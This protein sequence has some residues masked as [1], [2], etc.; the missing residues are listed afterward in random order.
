MPKAA[1]FITK[2]KKLA[3]AEPGVLLL[4]SGRGFGTPRYGD[5]LVRKALD[6]RKSFHLAREKLDSMHEAGDTLIHLMEV[7]D[8]KAQEKLRRVGRRSSDRTLA[9][10]DEIVESSHA[11][12]N[13]D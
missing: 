11:V 5:Q 12:R 4:L 3:S 2:G 6:A 10:F 9:L 7:K 13:L 8:K 1:G